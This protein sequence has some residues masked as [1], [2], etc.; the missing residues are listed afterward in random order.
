MDVSKFENFEM[1]EE[2][3]VILDGMNE[4]HLEIQPPSE[5]LLLAARET[6][7][8]DKNIN[9]RINAN[10]LTSIKLLA[11]REGIPYQTL[12]GSL[13]HKYTTGRLR[14]VA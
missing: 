2:E 11:A 6:L 3:K 5:S 13:I 12:I 1:D 4:G 9:I 10:D 7:R 14:D 8:K